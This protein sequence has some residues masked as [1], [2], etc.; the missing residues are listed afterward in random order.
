MWN[1]LVSTLQLVCG[2]LVCLMMFVLHGGCIPNVQPLQAF[3][4]D[5]EPILK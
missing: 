2:C 5:T 1:A 3:H 4:S